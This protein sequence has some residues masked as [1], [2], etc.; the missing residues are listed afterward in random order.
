[1]SRGVAI[2]SDRGSGETPLGRAVLATAVVLIVVTAALL[3]TCSEGTVSALYALV[4][5]AALLPGLPLGFALF[6]RRHGAGWVTGA[7]LGYALSA[8][9]L[10]AALRLG[11]RTAGA[12]AAAAL[13]LLLA[14]FA[15]R[16]SGRGR[17]PLIAL[18]PWGRRDT[19]ALLLVLVLV[20]VLMWAPY[21]HNG[22]ADATHTRHY[23]AYFTADFLW[24]MAMTGEL[25][26]GA[27]PP[28]N[29]FAAD[30]TVN[31]Y[32]TYFTLPAIGASLLAPH[33][34]AVEQCL[35]INAVLSGLLFV[36]A[37]FVATWAAVPRAGA[38]ALAV[39]LALLAASA[40]G[41]YGV[42][43]AFSRGRSLDALRAVNIGAITAWEFRGLRIDALPRALW[44][45]P[46]HAMACALGLT[47]V[48]A[49][50]A[51]ATIRLGGILL[52]GVS[53]G[54][55]LIFSP[56]L[57]ASL[58][59]IYGLTI[60]AGAWGRGAAVLREAVRHSL[61][62]VPVVAAFG[63]C[64]YNDMWE[65][66]GGALAFGF[67]G[68]ARRAP[69]ETLALALGPL[70]AA[71]LIALVLPGLR[72]SAV[73]HAVAAI[74]GLG[75]LYLVRLVP[76]PAWVGFRAGQILQITVPGLAALWIAWILDRRGAAR[77]ANAG[78][79][80]LLFVA[81][82]PTTVIDVWNAQ[83]TANRRMGP[84]FRW[85]I[86]IT[87]A[88][89]AAFVWI[90]RG[91]PPNA[92]VQ[93][94]ITSRGRETWSLIPSFAERRMAA[95]QPIALL[96]DEENRGRVARVTQLYR[97]SDAREAWTIA[98]DLGIDYV[99]VD[100]VER[101]HFAEGVSKFERAPHL[102]V[103]AFRNEEAAVYAV[104]KQGAG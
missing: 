38:A 76:D 40:Q 29:P 79:L 85:T 74:V 71:A 18:P 68:L 78:L 51:P 41:W 90:R 48:I 70:L 97:T 8:I 25:A 102:F 94:E 54:A 3:W 59:L 44:W 101:Q 36:S 88:Q 104:R 6:G 82:L 64:V 61:A 73:P 5:L 24:H 26:K 72:R 7:L 87:P 100:R 56:I 81:G 92:V 58:A 20:P 83:D 65:R 96:M 53:L 49:A 17:D 27:I 84:G 32:W 23:R 39:A 12:V 10:S 50:T 47:A 9:A 93:M 62:A 46:Q 37:V 80:V 57:G 42:Y 95:G 86:D 14:A 2:V 4:Y 66:A 15:G 11:I 91:T 60:L 16:R 103:P 52:V 22:A 45:T 19:L 30:Q 28:A 55:S 99:Y 43:D 34:N 75:L 63:W 13:L 67:G 35:E 21:A 69:A 77:W 31:Y 1:V 89:Q 33:A 98:N